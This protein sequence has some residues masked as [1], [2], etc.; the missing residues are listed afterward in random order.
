MDDKKGI[1]IGKTPL[2][3]M[4]AVTLSTLLTST[5][6]LFF[7]IAADKLAFDIT[8]ILKN[9]YLFLGFFLYAIAAAI[10]IKSLKYGELSILYPLIGLSY[11]WVTILS[12][13]YFSEQITVFKIL[14]VVIIIIG[15]TFIGVG[16]SK[17]II[18]KDKVRV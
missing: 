17:N 18:N 6:Q 4:I 1:W 7:K 3:A 9:Y 8:L 13:F 14:G 10:L 12:Y 11:V 15:I 16:S 2:W 5:A